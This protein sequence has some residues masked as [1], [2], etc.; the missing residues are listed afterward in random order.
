[1]EKYYKIKQEK[2]NEYHSLDR[3]FIS[4]PNFLLECNLNREA[5]MYYYWRLKPGSGDEMIV[6]KIKLEDLEEINI[7]KTL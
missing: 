1:M 5:G 4:F 6:T 3:A 2:I 7:F